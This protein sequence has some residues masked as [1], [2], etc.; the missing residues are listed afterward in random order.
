MQFNK[1]LLEYQLNSGATFNVMSISD[2]KMFS[3]L[4]S[5]ILNQSFVT[6]TFYGGSQ[7]LGSIVL[8]ARFKKS[9]YDLT[10]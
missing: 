1:K 8:K 6:L 4:D 2:L 5:P 7:S 9:F 3:G 10:F